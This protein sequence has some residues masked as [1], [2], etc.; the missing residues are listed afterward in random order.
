MVSIKL[1][2]LRVYYTNMY[3]R[4]LFDSFNLEHRSSLYLLNNYS[5]RPRI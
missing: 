4:E 3:W 2:K 1:I 5:L